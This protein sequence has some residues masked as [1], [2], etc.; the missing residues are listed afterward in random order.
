V[1]HDSPGAPSPKRD[2]TLNSEALARTYEIRL[3]PGAV[4]SVV[5]GAIDAPATG[6]LS[7]EDCLGGGGLLATCVQVALRSGSAGGPTTVLA[8]GCKD[9]FSRP[10]MDLR[11]QCRFALHHCRPS[12]KRS[13]RVT[14]ARG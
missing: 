1:D 8:P 5:R 10:T 13:D 4:D 14:Q 2:V 6:Q 3:A 7:R 11:S 9:V 12:S